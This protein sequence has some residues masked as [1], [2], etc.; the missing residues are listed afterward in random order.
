MSYEQDYRSA[1]GLTTHAPD[2]EIPVYVGMATFSDVEDRPT[3]HPRVGW[4]I[5]YRLIGFACVALA[6]VAIY[7]GIKGA[8]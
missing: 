8:P 3:Q 1:I 5:A 7:F 6:T 4:R 2:V